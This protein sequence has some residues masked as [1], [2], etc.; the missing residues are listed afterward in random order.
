M[1][2]QPTTLPSHHQ[3]LPYH[4]L[5]I[6]WPCCRDTRRCITLL[7]PGSLCHETS[8]LGNPHATITPIQSPREPRD[9]VHECRITFCG[10]MVTDTINAQAECQLYVVRYPYE[11]PCLAQSQAMH[12]RNASRRLAEHSPPTPPQAPPS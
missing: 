11:L 12:L 8:A 3:N 1:P 2:A 9:P 7:V 10:T 4:L 5:I 6:C